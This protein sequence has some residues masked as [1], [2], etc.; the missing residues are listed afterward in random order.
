[1]DLDQIE[2]INSRSLRLAPI[3]LPALERDGMLTLKSIST[4]SAGHTYLEL[5]CEF[6]FAMSI[7]ICCCR[8]AVVWLGP[9]VVAEAEA[10]AEATTTA[11]AGPMWVACWGW[12]VSGGG[13]LGGC[14]V[15]LADSLALITCCWTR[16]GV[17]GSEL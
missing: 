14:M 4:R 11:A 15:M 1:M 7:I 6:G 9:A 5:L 12:P 17:G 16:V 2:R 3:Y 13:G 10:A 8:S